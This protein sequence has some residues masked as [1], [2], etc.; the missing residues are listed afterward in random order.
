MTTNPYQSPQSA[1]GD[2]AMNALQVQTLPAKAGVQWFLLALR[3]FRRNLL[4]YIFFSI[5]VGLCFSL[6]MGLSPIFEFVHEFYDHRPLGEPHVSSVPQEFSALEYGIRESSAW[7]FIIIFFKIGIPIC[8]LLLPV[9]VMC[10]CAVY[11]IIDNEKFITIN[12]LWNL[13]KKNLVFSLVYG[14]LLA[15]LFPFTLHFFIRIIIAR[16]VVYNFIP[17]EYIFLIIFIPFF[18]IIFW[19]LFFLRVW[20]NLS[21]FRLIYYSFVAYFRNWKSFSV[22]GGL[23]I[24]LILILSVIIGVVLNS[25]T[26]GMQLFF[27][28]NLHDKLKIT[29][30]TTIALF[31]TSG[32]MSPIM[33]ANIYYSY[34]AIFMVQNKTSFS[35][36]P[37]Q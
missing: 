17:I 23:S 35:H 13:I 30:I 22:N 7:Y 37:V 6:V 4:I 31:I 16:F 28:P 27:V 21:I 15:L 12:N 36:S 2:S 26:D 19:S 29:A 9:L 14:F 3:L 8:S 24:A 18:I 1:T 20:E 34:K 11:R 10:V 33:F 5:P 32:I 25:A